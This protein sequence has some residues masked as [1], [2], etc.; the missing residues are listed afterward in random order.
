MPIIENH[1][2]GG[3]ICMHFQ[4]ERLNFREFRESDFPL[5]YSVFS[6][7]QIM[8]YAL[9]DRYDNEEDALPYFR[10]IL[11]NNTIDINR[12]AFEF[13]VFLTGSDEFI[14]FAD[15]EVHYQNLSGGC[16]EIGYF[17]LP[18]YWGNGFATEMTNALIT[19]CFKQIKL[20][21][22]VASCHAN[23]LQSEKIMKKVGMLKEGEFRKARFKNGQWDNEL[24]YSIL[25][26]EWKY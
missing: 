15:I 6:T 14:G 20:H 11:K 22:I 8:K 12:E 1:H 13:A 21:R 5:F 7:E 23:N 16:G 24:R 9:M 10:K 3:I 18:S 25:I 4:S 2:H 26:D 17:L 19:I